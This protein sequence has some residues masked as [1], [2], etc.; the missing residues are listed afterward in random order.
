MSDYDGCYVKLSDDPTFWAVDDGKRRK[1]SDS[2]ALF[3]IGLRPVRVISIDELGKLKIEEHD[4]KEA[5][6]EEE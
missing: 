2:L 4:P 6:D 5:S 1:V 3:K